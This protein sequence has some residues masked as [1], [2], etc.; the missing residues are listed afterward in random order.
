LK[1]TD[2]SMEHWRDFV[3]VYDEEIYLLLLEAI[4]LQQGTAA[5]LLPMFLKLSAVQ[6]SSE[7]LIRNN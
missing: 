6:T 3:K 4:V 7:S 1:Y 2:W 5:E